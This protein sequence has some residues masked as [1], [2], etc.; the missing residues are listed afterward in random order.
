MVP[1]LERKDLQDPEL[2]RHGDGA[3]AGVLMRFAALNHVTSVPIEFRRPARAPTSATA[4]P[5]AWPPS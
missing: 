4:E 3:I 1:R 5:T 2:V